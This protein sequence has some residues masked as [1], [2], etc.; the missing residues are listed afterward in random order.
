MTHCR[1]Q[2]AHKAR[3]ITNNTRPSRHPAQDKWRMRCGALQT[4]ETHITGQSKWH[5]RCGANMT[6]HDRTRQLMHWIRYMR[7]EQMIHTNQRIRQGRWGVTLTL[8]NWY[9]TQ[10][11]ENVKID[12]WHIE[13]VCH[14]FSP[15]KLWE[16]WKGNGKPNHTSWREWLSVPNDTSRSFYMTRPDTTWHADV[17]WQ[18]EIV[19]VLILRLHQAIRYQ[20][21]IHKGQISVEWRNCAISSLIHLPF[22]FL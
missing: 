17:V 8:S 16:T 20:R 1:G 13:Q 10:S 3:S 18:N 14:L 21:V 19:D 2:L 6:R 11:V 5:M 15:F 4:Q 7:T 22:F 12:T 9:A